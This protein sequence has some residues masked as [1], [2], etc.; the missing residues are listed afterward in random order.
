LKPLAVARGQL[1]AFVF[2][3]LARNGDM[4]ASRILAFEVCETVLDIDSMKKRFKVV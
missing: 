1:A 3:T 4:R 2:V